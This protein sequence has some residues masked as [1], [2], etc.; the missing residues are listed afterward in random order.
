MLWLLARKKK[1]C[2]LLQLQKPPLLPLQLLTSLLQSPLLLTQRL[3]PLLTLLL[4]LPPLRTLL[5]PL[6]RLLP[7]LRTLLRLLLPSNWYR[8][9]AFGRLA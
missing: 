8:T 3:L 2:L 6:H 5:P 1:K 9:A 4:L 7:L